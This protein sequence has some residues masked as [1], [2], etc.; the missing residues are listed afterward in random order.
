MCLGTGNL[1]FPSAIDKP[2]RSPVRAAR[3]KFAPPPPGNVL[4]QNPMK[5]TPAFPATRG[6]GNAAKTNNE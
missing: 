3:S 4:R 2:I 5:A 6:I 1:A